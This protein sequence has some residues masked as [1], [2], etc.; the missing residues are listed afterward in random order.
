MRRRVREGKGLRTVTGGS[1]DDQR[2]TA[3]VMTTGPRT[4]N[5]DNMRATDLELSIVPH[6]SVQPDP[7][8]TWMTKVAL[9]RP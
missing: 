1:P 3:S 5:T 2:T 6:G 9:S 4:E 8:N 7:Q